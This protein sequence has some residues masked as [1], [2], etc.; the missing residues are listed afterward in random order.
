MLAWHLN[1]YYVNEGVNQAAGDVKFKLYRT[2]HRKQ[3]DLEHL[4]QL[5]FELRMLQSDFLG[6]GDV[7]PV[8]HELGVNSRPLKCIFATLNVAWQF[9]VVLQVPVLEGKLDVRLPT[10]LF[11]EDDQMS[12]R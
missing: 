12:S 8:D 2:R 7:P 5:S 3:I 6:L 11:L 1:V 4:A 10:D 9:L